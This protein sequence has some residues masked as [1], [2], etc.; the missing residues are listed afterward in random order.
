M[1]IKNKLV[2][3]DDDDDADNNKKKKEEKYNIQNMQEEYIL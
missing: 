2:M 1:D 3:N